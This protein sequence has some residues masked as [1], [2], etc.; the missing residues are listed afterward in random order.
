MGRI[1]TRRLNLDAPAGRRTPIA[2]ALVSMGLVALMLGGCSS[3][4]LFAEDKQQII[5]EEP[6]DKLYNEGVAFMNKGEYTQATKRFEELDRQ[7]PYSELARKSV[8]MVAF[9]NYRLGR[10]EEAITAGQRYVTLHPGSPDAAY[11]HYIVAQA[12]YNQITDVTRD[13]GA[14]EKALASLQEVV[15]LY[16]DSEY[17]PD[18]QKKIDVA[19]DQL[20]GREMQVGR[21]YLERRLYSGAVNRFK[22]V[23]QNYQTTRHVEEALYRLTESYMSLGIV[24]EAQTAAAVLGHNFPDSPWYQDSF[25][26]LRTGGLS[27]KE[28]Q[29]S[30][31]SRAWKR[32]V[33]T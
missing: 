28:D 6:A 14:T 15:R 26:L 21:Y 5:P 25:K 3:I 16:P 24:N 8:L 17:A 27:P 9:T 11:A 13:Q 10:Y 23:V 18:A 2:R 33:R 32:I 12:H 29:G 31:I 30:W 19:R 20:A 1:V 22:T 7:H 4:N